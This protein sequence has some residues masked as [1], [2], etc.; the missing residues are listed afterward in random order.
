VWTHDSIGLGE[1]GPTHQPIEHLA[2]LRAIPGLDVVRPADANETVAAWKTV[3]EHNDRPAGL[4]LSRQNVPTFPR[5]TDG[6]SDT[7]NV[8][9]GGYVLVDSP[10]ELSAIPDVVLVGTGSEV[11]LA[12]EARDLLAADGIA[13]R[14]VS[15]PCREWYDAQETSYRETVIPPTVKARVSVE[16]GIAQGWR[17]VVGDHGR[18]VSIEHY[19]ASADYDRIYREFGTT[20]EAVAQAARDSIAA[21]NA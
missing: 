3:L 2:A 7:S 9:R 1:D 18:I 5:G 20:A 14:V 15:M 13:A 17:E 10:S 4:C 6:Y 21:A 12:V 19:G 8:H 11:Q 16:A